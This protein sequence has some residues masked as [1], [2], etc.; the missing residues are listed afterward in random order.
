MDI[1]DIFPVKGWFQGDT[2]ATTVTLTDYDPTLWT[3]AYT[4]NRIGAAKITFISTPGAGGTFLMS[5]AKTVTALY[6]PG[7]YYL[8][9]TIT[10]VSDGTRVTLGQVEGIIW[11]DPTTLAGDP[12]SPNRIAFD[13]VE[14]ALASG[15]GSDVVE[16]TIAGTQMKKDRAGLLALRAFYLVRVRAEQGKP[17]LGNV[18]YSL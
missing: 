5:V 1:N 15:A 17:A 2:I 9:A 8:A 18:L 11:P 14:A 4:F 12:R 16:Y 3:L 10:K 7:T 6:A 13:S